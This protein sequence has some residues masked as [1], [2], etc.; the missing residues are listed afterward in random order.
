MKLGSKAFVSE[1]GILKIKKGMILAGPVYQK[2][3]SKK[4]VVDLEHP[5]EG[6]TEKDVKTL[7]KLYRGKKIDAK[8][9]VHQT[10]PFAPFM[11]GGAILTIL[12]R[13]NFISSLVS[14]FT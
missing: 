13:G 4:K 9:K 5:A 14:L 7:L 12:L 1:I 6:L 8:L 3:G 11:F 2:V 10:L